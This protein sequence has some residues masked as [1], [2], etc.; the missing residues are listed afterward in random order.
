MQSARSAEDQERV[1]TRYAQQQGW[2]VVML[3]RDEAVRAGAIASRDG[4]ARLLKA[5]RAKLFD[6]LIVEEVSRFSRD[7]L[8]G[9]A[10]LAALAKLKVRLADTR[11]G[12]ID[13]ATAAGQMQSAVALMMS[14]QETQRLGE[15]S[16]RGLEGKVHAGFSSGGRPAYG[17]RREPIFSATETDV[18]GRPKRTGV[19]LVPDPLTAPV[20]QRIFSAYAMGASKG[21]IARALNSE[22]ISSRDIG[23]RHSGKMNSGTW[24][25]GS[26]KTL[27]ENEV[28]IGERAWNK[29]SRTGDKLRSGKKAMR[30]NPESEWIR[31]KDYAEPVVDRETW[32]RVQARLRADSDTYGATRTAKV[33]RQY[34]LSGKIVCS[35]CGGSFVIGSMLHGVRQYRCGVRAQRGN[36]VCT[37]STNVPQAALEVKVRRVLDV[38]VKDPDKLGELVAEHNRLV[39]DSN[40]EH[41]SAVRRI[42]A[43]LVD[44]RAA[45]DR[46][47]EAIEAGAAVKVLTEKLAKR[48]REIKQLEVDLARA[49]A[50]VQPTLQPRGL[51]RWQVAGGNA[52]LFTGDYTHDRGLIDQVVTAITVGRDGVIT[53]AFNG[54]SLFGS[55]REYEVMPGALEAGV[56][57]PLQDERETHIVASD[58]QVPAA[59]TE[60]G[61][62][63][64]IRFEYRNYSE[65]TVGVPSG[66]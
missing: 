16:K 56:D 13:M 54:P 36:E 14:H 57:A 51:D 11:N 17:L 60:Y 33:N 62:D 21:E 28:Y 5:A 49:Q 46:L 58:G 10:E 18:D 65:K 59:I 9:M 38:L 2:T 25:R 42:E 15:R 35:V 6:T 29:H 64:L 32:N 48:E 40:S 7:F 22:R 19:K 1:C 43:Q 4:Y 47:V 26:I 37:N 12:V 3:E 39:G 61:E 50:S 63:S 55:V 44:A 24:T 20:V 30:P 23:K 31:V 66:I 8:G 27:L 34:L 41:L 52:S 45:Q 53:L